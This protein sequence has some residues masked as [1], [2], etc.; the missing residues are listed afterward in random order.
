L[1]VVVLGVQQ[2]P[3]FNVLRANSLEKVSGRL[4]SNQR[5]PA[6]KADFKRLLRLVAGARPQWIANERIAAA[7]LRPVDV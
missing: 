4:D 1:S 2:L 7:V 6:P 3:T 5:P